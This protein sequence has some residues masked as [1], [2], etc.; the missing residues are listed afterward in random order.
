VSAS[1]ASHGVGVRAPGDEQR[2]ERGGS[3][4]DA[5]GVLALPVAGA[6]PGSEGSEGHALGTQ[7][8]IVLHVGGVA[9]SVPTVGGGGSSI[10][11][12]AL[13]ASHV[14]TTSSRG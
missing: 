3:A 12:H 6:A 9:G 7:T 14:A 13:A 10:P 5:P 8:R 2:H 4:G 11:V 1:S